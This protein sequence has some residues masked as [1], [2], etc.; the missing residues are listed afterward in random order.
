L[1][2]IALVLSYFWYHPPKT[3]KR[4][5]N[6]TKREAFAQIDWIGVFLQTAGIILLLVG[7]TLGGTY[8]WTDKRTLSPLVIGIATLIVYGLWEWKGAK[9][10]FLAHDLFAGKLRTYVLFLVVDF[11]AGIG[12][13]TAAAFW[14]QLARGVWSRSPIA[15]GY[16]NIPGGFGIAAGGF[17]AGM[18]I[19]RFKWMNTRWCLVW[20]CV[21]K[22]VAD[23]A[24][25]HIAVTGAHAESYG[26]GLFFL[27]LFGTG[28]TGVAL[29]VCV[30][31]DCA[32][33]DIGM[34]TLVLGAVRAIGGSV[35][36]TVFSTILN[37]QMTKHAGD[38]VAAAV[39]PL[40][41]NSAYAVP[42]VF[43]LINENYAAVQALPGM[44]P[45]IFAAAKLAIEESWRQGFHNMY[46]CSGALAAFSVVAAVL[47][48]DVSNNMTDHV[49][50][51]LLNEKPRPDKA[52]AL[53]KGNGAK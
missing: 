33:A 53:E 18:T 32:D 49:A 47:T 31:L 30:Q 40:G 48:K 50:V 39:L 29:L 26:M 37:N 19:G 52:A 12:L 28:W 35:G 13:Y 38:D 20:G 5:G 6:R 15:V 24:L 41:F 42:L 3:G 14:A 36:I 44:T 46:L 11:V 2:V 22:T 4:L 43:D 34:A 25:S 9:H 16:L 1:N 7:I 23:F 21:F 45:A 51:R 27:S 8:P 10:P 17:L